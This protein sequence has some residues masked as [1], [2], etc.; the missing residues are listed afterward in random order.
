MLRKGEAKSQGVSKGPGQGT[1]RERHRV[2][3]DPLGGKLGTRDQDRL[4]EADTQDVSQ[5]R[6][7]VARL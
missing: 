7:M 6:K 3:G 1:V 5:K 2:R 4:L